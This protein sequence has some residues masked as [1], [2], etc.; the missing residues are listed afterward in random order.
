MKKPAKT[1]QSSTPKSAKKN[2]KS[3]KR[4]TVEAVVK[5]GKEECTFGNKSGCG[6]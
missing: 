5:A 3:Q 6:T 1:N 4:L 2:P